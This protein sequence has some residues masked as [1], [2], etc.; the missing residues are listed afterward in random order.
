MS[1]ELVLVARTAGVD[2]PDKDKTSVAATL[3]IRIIPVN[4]V[5]PTIVNNTGLTM[6]AG[7][8]VPILLTNLGQFSYQL[9]I[10]FLVVSSSLFTLPEIQRRT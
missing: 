1:D 3:S 5:S 4:D 10:M 7:T 6:W 9:T 8:T 2:W